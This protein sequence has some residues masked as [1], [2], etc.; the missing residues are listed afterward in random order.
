MHCWNIRNYVSN[1]IDRFRYYLFIYKGSRRRNSRR[2]NSHSISNERIEIINDNKADKL[3]ITNSISIN[4]NTKQES[5]IERAENIVIQAQVEKDIEKDDK[6]TENLNKNNYISTNNNNLETE[7]K[8]SEVKI[9]TS[10]I[11]IDCR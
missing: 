2:T 1:I 11:Y 5:K 4:L 6:N 9:N 10:K 3:Q 8:F 7:T